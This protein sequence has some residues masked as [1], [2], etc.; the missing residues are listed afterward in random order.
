MNLVSRN[1]NM[2]RPL[3]KI[4]GLLSLV[5]AITS[6]RVDPN[7]AG[8]EY[9][10]DMYRSPALEAYVDYGSNKHMDWTLQQKEAAGVKMKLSRKPV[11]GTVPFMES[12]MKRATALCATDANWMV[13]PYALRNTPDDYE[14][15]ASDIKSPLISNKVNIEKGAELY[16]KMCAHCH[17]KEGKGDGKISASGKIVAPDYPGKLKDL[18]E[19]KMY[20][21][22]T[23]GKG[24]M[25][26]HASQLTKLERWQVIEFVKCLQKGITT[27]EYDKDGKL[28]VSAA[29]PAAPAAP[30]EPA[31][32]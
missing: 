14:R 31:K 17:G 23:Y 5:L 2:K 16:Q 3:M 12:D 21:S 4:A 30:A 13:M 22:I 18:P 26:S 11:D 8:Y 29:A 25:G 7:S 1:I 10:P 6:C 20:H 15:S 28:V 27:P 32:P 24:L 9:M 19:G